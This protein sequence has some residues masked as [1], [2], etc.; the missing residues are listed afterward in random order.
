MS[1]AIAPASSSATMSQSFCGRLVWDGVLSHDEKTI[2][3][4]LRLRARS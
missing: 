2:D 1:S 3:L 4:G